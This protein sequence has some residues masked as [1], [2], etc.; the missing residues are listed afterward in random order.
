MHQAQA[1]RMGDYD[2]ARQWHDAEWW[3]HHHPNWVWSHHPDWVRS[4][5]EWHRDGD[6]DEQH[7]WHS[8][9]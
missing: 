5:A 2:D 7:Y 9:A 3:F 1:A 6:W 4:H 8:R